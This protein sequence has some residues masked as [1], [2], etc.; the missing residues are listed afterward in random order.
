MSK[1]KGLHTTLDTTGSAAWED[2]ESVLPYVDLVL[3]DIKHL[4]THVHKQATGVSNELVL[5]IRQSRFVNSLFAEG[6]E[7]QEYEAAAL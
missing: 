7:Q 5:E 6:F 4:D 2:L 1:E 3:W